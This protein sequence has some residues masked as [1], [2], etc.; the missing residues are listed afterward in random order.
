MIIWVAVLLVLAL[1]GCGSKSRGFYRDY[2][3][4]ER[5]QAVKGV[6]LL[7]VF[8]SHF[9]QYVSLAGP[10]DEPYFALRRYLGQLVVAPF[11]FYSGY[12]LGVSIQ[13]KG[14]AYV[15]AMPRKRLFWVWLQFLAA[16][17]LFFPAN[18]VLGRTFPLGY[19]LLALTGWESI[20]NSNWYVF[21]ILCL[22]GFTWLGFRL[23]PRNKPLAALAVTVLAAGY[24]LVLRQLK[25]GYWFNMIL[26]YPAGLWFSLYRDRAEEL[27][28]SGNRAY[29]LTLAGLI[30]AFWLL[31]RFWAN[32]I[33]CELTAVL[34]PL[35][36]ALV[37]AKV[38]IRSRV[39]DYCGRHL[40][41]LFILQRLP[42]MLLRPVFSGSA[43][44]WYF[45]ACLAIT[46][47]L[48]YGFDFVFGKLKT[49]R[50]AK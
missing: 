48:S 47:P 26:A 20:G 7:L 12:G 42:M 8:A 40:F 18:L 15:R 29:G 2:M 35:I 16:L 3:A 22:Y 9:V 31:H 32:L 14:E 34:F 46:F 30:A 17:A 5:I 27:F 43:W 19:S 44:Y 23:F 37:T 25:P 28:F 21:A 10:L 11:L 13:A 24:I 1:W 33:C 50:V 6:F 36:L 38:S 39:L 49:G 45:L 4:L 41:S